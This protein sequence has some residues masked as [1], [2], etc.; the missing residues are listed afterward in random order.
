M[1][2]FYLFPLSLK[3]FARHCTV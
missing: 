3:S 2:I 1:D